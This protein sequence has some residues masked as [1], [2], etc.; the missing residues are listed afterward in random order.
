M[1]ATTETNENER[2]PNHRQNYVRQCNR[3]IDDIVDLV[4]GNV[5]TTGTRITLGALIV[6]DVHGEAWEWGMKRGCEGV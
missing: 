2:H 1:S 4:R 5:I 6:I 3:Q